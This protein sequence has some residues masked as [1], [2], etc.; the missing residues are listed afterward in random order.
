MPMTQKIRDSVMV[1][2]KINLQKLNLAKIIV[3]F[4]YFL[5][6]LSFKVFAAIFV[7]K[8]KLP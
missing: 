5:F 1:D 2:K 8:T 6:F 7:H 3:Y 4:S